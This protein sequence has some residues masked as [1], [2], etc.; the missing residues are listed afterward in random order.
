MC[1]K[2]CS[3]VV[4]QLLKRLLPLTLSRE[5]ASVLL[6]ERL[7]HLIPNVKCKKKSHEASG[8][9]R[10]HLFQPDFM[11]IL[12]KSWIDHQHLLSRVCAN[13]LKFL[14]VNFFFHYTPYIYLSCVFFCATFNVNMF[15][16]TTSSIH[17]CSTHQVL[18]GFYFGFYW[19]VR[20]VKSSETCH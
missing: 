15:K 14:Q 16:L 4:I 5:K 10:S 1:I 3:V 11:S 20:S 12:H 6:G 7:T 19:C 8:W 9:I 2:W 17:L 18:V 13:S